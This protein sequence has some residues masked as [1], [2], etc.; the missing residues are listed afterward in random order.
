MYLHAMN[1]E[2][3]CR[4]AWRAVAALSLTCPG[5][6]AFE[7]DPQVRML[8]GNGAG[9]G[10]VADAIFNPFETLSGARYLTKVTLIVAATYTGDGTLLNGDGQAPPSEEPAS[11]VTWQTAQYSVRVEVPDGTPAGTL[12][13]PPVTLRAGGFVAGPIPADQAVSVD[14]AAAGGPVTYLYTDT[15]F[16]NAFLGPDPTLTAYVAASLTFW[17]G[18]LGSGKQL[19]FDHFNEDVEVTL[20]LQYSYV[21]PE[22]GTCG[23]FAGFGLLGFAAWRRKSART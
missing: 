2:G 15:S 13:S 12:T 5:L 9:G 14:I 1:Q 21:V 20:A 7:L 22:P 16:L 4:P 10:W 17:A 8:Q 11:D 19:D 6:L 23:L 3:M 18:N